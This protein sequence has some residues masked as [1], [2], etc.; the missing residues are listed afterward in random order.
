MPT[1]PFYVERALPCACLALASEPFK[2]CPACCGVGE[3]W[4]EIALVVTYSA[5]RAAR[6]ARD[7]YGAQLEPDEEASVEIVS[8]VD[9]KGVE[10]T[11][12]T[13]EENCAEE[14]CYEDAEE[15]AAS[16]YAED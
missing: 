14:A 2:A 9:E 1:I 3:A 10:V 5:T 6:G 16:R 8:V 4:Q 7:R 13:H 12:T 15:S 11:L